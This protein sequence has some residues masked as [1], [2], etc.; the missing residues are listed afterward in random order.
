MLSSTSSSSAALPW[1]LRVA[2]CLVTV[3]VAATVV[4]ADVERETPEPILRLDLPGHTAEVRSL[5]FLPD[6]RLVSGGRDKVAMIWDTRDTAAGTRDIARKRIR[7]RVI[8]WQVARGTRGVIQALAASPEKMTVV[9]IGGSGAMGSTGEILV[10]DHADGSL[11]AVLGGGDRPGHRGSVVGLDFST[12]AAWLFSSD[13]DGQVFAW[14]RDKQDRAAAWRPVELSGRDETRLPAVQVAAV[15]A[16]PATRPLAAVQ[17]GRVA[18]PTIV[19]AQPPEAAPVWNIELVDPAQA[20]P[21]EVLPFDHKGVILAM[22]ATPDGR[23]LAVADLAGRAVVW[24]LAAAKPRPVVLEIS[25]AAETLAL[26]AD[27]RRLIAGVATKAG[28]PARLEIWDVT[29]GQRVSTRELAAPVRA[30]AASATGAIFAASGGWNHEIIVDA[31]DV[32]LAQAPQAAPAD[33]PRRPTRRLGGV[34]RRIGRV[35]F[36]TQEGKQPPQRLAVSL[37]P[38]SGVPEADFSAAF[39]IVNLAVVPVGDRA[40]W[41]PSAGTPGRWSLARSPRQRDGFESW[42]LLDGGRAAAAIELDLSWQG[43]LGPATECVAWLTRAGEAEPWAVVLGTD[44]GLFVCE[45]AKAGLCRI[46]R[47]YRGHEDGV[48]SLAVS[49]DGRWLA[50]GGRDGLVMLWPVAGIDPAQPLFER[51]GIGLRLENGRAVVDSLDEAGPLAGRDVRVE[52][53]I[54]KV[55]WADGAGPAGGAAE[56]VTGPAVLA[57]LTDCPWSRQLSVVVERDGNTAPPFNRLPAW[58]NIASLHLAANREWAWWSPRG[59]YA[60]S[61]NGDSLFGW[62]VNRGVE[63]LPRFFRANQFRRRLERPDVMS[64]ILIA[65]SLG[66]ALRT[67]GRDQ[68]KSSAVVLPELIV[69]TPE[70]NITSPRS[71]AAA[72]AATIRVTASIDIPAG[73]TLSRA[74]AYASGVVGRDEGRIVE[75]LPAQDGRPARRTYAWDLALPAESEHLIQVFAGTESGPTDVAELTVAAPVAVAAAPPRR[76]RLFLLAAGVDRYAHADRFGHFGLTHLAFATA[77]ARAIQ[78]ALGRQSA[79]RY[80]I[81]GNVLLADA[82]V[83][84]AAWRES[85]ATAARRLADDVAPD[86][87]VVIFLAGHGMI[88]ESRG[89][90]YC[91]LCHDAELHDLPTGVVAD[92]EGTIR[93]QDFA[94]L[95]GLPCRKLALVDTCHSGGMGPSTR[96]TAVREFQENMIL[97]L[98]AASDAEASQESD[99]WGHG[100]FTTC[101]LEALD[102]RADTRSGRLRTPSGTAWD[103]A[104]APDGVVTLAEIA[105][106]V[107]AR[108]PELTIAAGER[109]QHPTVSPAALV[110]FVTLPLADKRGSQQPP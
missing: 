11:V 33:T 26:S 86:D 15:K 29:T 110:P 58:E 76:P 75:D 1:T 12:D 40:G 50:S 70:V 95:D 82:A 91:Y 22:D 2:C 66:A 88:D 34:G 38:A 7:D 5:A 9:A 13:V 69:A 41:A 97:V 37:L 56:A 54:A 59:Y 28:S 81:A 63:R 109:P 8:R 24:D 4:R 16:L 35:A 93:W 21:R 48:L 14:E 89:R 6:G 23:F 45:L 83:T 98:A 102:G 64:Q 80:D 52:D 44:R 49:E 85:L 65:G 105:D 18:L 90:E 10:V 55:S 30:T 31:S 39:D 32:A 108:V 103:P 46:V 79:T 61:A 60:A 84:R 36:S 96:S 27:G 71:D 51:F 94:A 17:G 77:D 99:A 57:A 19:P 104:T 47:R 78:A 100:A 3:A 107:A 68:P 73:V 62:L 106:Y 42:Q 74:R 43:R 101:L 25:P 87:L 72:D 20:V 53:V 92:R 67:A